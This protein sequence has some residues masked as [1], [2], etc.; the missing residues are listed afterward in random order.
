VSDVESVEKQLHEISHVF[1]RMSV[2]VHEQELMVETI[3]SSTEDALL[4]LH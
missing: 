4:S 2:M 3:H 1:Q